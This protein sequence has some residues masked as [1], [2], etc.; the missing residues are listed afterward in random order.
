[1]GDIMIIRA[2]TNNENK[3][4]DVGDKFTVTKVEKIAAFWIVELRKEI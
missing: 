1:M 3:V 2:D 4:P